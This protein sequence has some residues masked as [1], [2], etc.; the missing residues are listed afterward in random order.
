MFIVVLV[1]IEL[2]NG[3][4]KVVFINNFDWECNSQQGHFWSLPWP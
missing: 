2:I 1:L 3:I 4:N